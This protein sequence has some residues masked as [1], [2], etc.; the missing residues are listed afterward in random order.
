[1]KGAG[2]QFTSWSTSTCRGFQAVG[3]LSSGWRQAAAGRPL[4][5]RPGDR[6]CHKRLA[7]FS[8]PPYEAIADQVRRPTLV[9]AASSSHG[10][11]II[12]LGWLSI[13]NIS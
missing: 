10:Y 2:L 4:K 8:V 12:K 6:R 5:Q 11:S 7:Q 3:A 13:A 9:V 1:V